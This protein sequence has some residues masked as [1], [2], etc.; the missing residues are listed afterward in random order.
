M[1]QLPGWP[2]E[3]KMQRGGHGD[4]ERQYR[5]TSREELALACPSPIV[6]RVYIEARKRAGMRFRDCEWRSF[7]Q[8]GRRNGSQLK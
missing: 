3:R 6:R 5:V 8:R 2:L 7:C 4:R 1:F